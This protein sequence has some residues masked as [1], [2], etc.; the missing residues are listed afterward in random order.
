MATR[1]KTRYVL[2]LK[3]RGYAAS[4]EIRKVYRVKTD[5]EAESH[6]LLR[7]IDETGGDYLYPERYFVDIEV[8][9]EAA[10]A[11]IQSA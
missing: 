1:S 10:G 7:V 3:N 4:L 9:R 6:G 8:P 2:C 11:F 5:A